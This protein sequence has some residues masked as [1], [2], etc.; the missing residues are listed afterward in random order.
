[1]GNETTLQFQ[2]IEDNCVYFYDKKRKTYR[3]ICDVESYGSLP[4]SVKRQI[5][6][7]KEEAREA[8]LLPTQ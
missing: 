2:A 6:I 8:D 3:K 7:V 5:A 4:A 1:M